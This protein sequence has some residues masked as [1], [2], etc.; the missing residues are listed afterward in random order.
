MKRVVTAILAAAG[1]C[2]LVPGMPAKAQETKLLFAEVVPP[3]SVIDAKVVQPWAQRV[4]QQG[5][6]VLSID[7]RSGPSLA[8]FGN[9]YDRVLSDV[10]QI[11]WEIQAAVGGKFP[12]SNV[13]ALPLITDDSVA[14]TVA[15][16]RLYQSG[17]LASEYDQVVPIMLVTLPPAAF[18]FSK[19]LTNLDT[20]AGEKLIVPSK[21]AGD[22][23]A[24]LGGAPLSLPLTDMY[25]AIQRGT[26]DGT[27]IAW[28]AFNPWKL[29]DVTSY[30][31]D[32]AFG[33]AAGMIFMSKAKYNSLTPAARKIIADN[34]GEA[35]SRAFGQAMMTENAAQ[36]AAVAALPKQTIV[37]PT[38]AQVASWRQK[39]TPTIEQ[40]TKSTKGGETVLAQFKTELAKIK[41]G[42]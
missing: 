40:W 24:A 38:P 17:A 21:V 30:H 31:I 15:F 29:A 16:W 2:V 37:T 5:K 13:V 39:I 34:S 19:P 33:G 3:G 8:D 4:N 23:L 10:I 9:I 1:I 12:L 20:L 28:V 14:S 42:H 25:P 22:A 27:M 11:G 18:H 36:R 6:G 7:V 41:T 26:A 35:F 32:T